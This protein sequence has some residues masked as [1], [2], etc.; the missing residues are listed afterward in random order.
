MV[1]LFTEKFNS[2]N[3][4]NKDEYINALREMV[5]EIALYSLSNTNFFDKAAFCGG[6]SLRIFYY[7]D[8]ASEDLDFSLIVQ[9][10]DFSLTP[11][12]KILE[13]YFHD[14]GFSFEAVENKNKSNVLSAFLKGGTII[15]LIS[16]GLPKELTKGI[17]DTELLKIKIELDTNPPK[18]AEYEFKYGT[19]PFPYKVRIFNKETLFA[20]KLHAIL[21]RDWNN[22]IKG[23]DYYDFAFYVRSKTKI[24][25]AQLEAALKQSGHLDSKETLTPELLKKMLLNK[26]SSIDFNIAKNDVI[27]F[28]KNPRSIEAWDNDLFKYITIEYFKRNYNI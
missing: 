26:I 23:R 20:G 8:R 12:L 16:I 27:R 22:N 28:I 18:N 10:Q 6:T 19:F 9:N 17:R 13:G 2:Y 4:T 1:N 7:L 5:Q 21:C 25:F 24:N 14:F 11:Y 3:A 15:N